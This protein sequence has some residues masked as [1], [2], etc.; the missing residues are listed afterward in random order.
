[1]KARPRRVENRVAEELTKWST[2]RGD[3]WVFERWPAMGRVGP[4][5]RFPNPY[6][7]VIDVK[8]RQS[9]SNKPWLITD[10]NRD[11]KWYVGDESAGW[12]ICRLDCLDVMFRTNWMPYKWHSIVVDGWL[13]HM[14]EWA[15]EHSGIGIII[16]HKPRKPIGSSIVLIKT[17]DWLR[18][19]EGM[20]LI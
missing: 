20:E 14:R 15:H 13:E 7:F 1:M 10:L 12:Y 5:V 2:A 16:L 6:H 4:D 8:S 19:M 3:H 9:I 17:T 18:L 11:V